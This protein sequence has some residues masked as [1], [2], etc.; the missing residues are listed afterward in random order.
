M[1][2]SIDGPQDG[3]KTFSPQEIIAGVRCNPLMCGVLAVCVLAP[4]L[5]LEL[6]AISTGCLHHMH[7]ASLVNAATYQGRCPACCGGGGLR[8]C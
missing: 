5:N 4:L 6:E 7:V 8:A 2:D 1:R 3:D